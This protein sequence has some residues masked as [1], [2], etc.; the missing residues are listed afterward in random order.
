MT[1]IKTL[2]I[3]FDNPI[4]REEIKFFR[5][6]VISSLQEKNVLFHNH[7]E[8]GYRYAYPLI[9]YKRIHG[10]AAIFCIGEGVDAIYGYFTSNNFSYQLGERHIEAKLDHILAQTF[11]SEKSDSLTSYR[12]KNWLPLNKENYTTYQ[13]LDNMVERIGLL[14][15]ILVGNLM[16]LFKG[17]GI[18]TDTDIKVSITDIKSQHTIRYKDVRLSAFDMEFKTNVQLPDYIGIGKS[19]SQ[20]F[21]IVEAIDKN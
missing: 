19:V 10:K 21:G 9:Q 12:V 14:E 15:K 4:E 7:V 13:Q 1:E 16:S 5:A 20:G 17:I 2:L 6:A 11:T 18:H 3:Q 8:E